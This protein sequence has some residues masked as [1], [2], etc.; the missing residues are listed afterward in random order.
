MKQLKHMRYDYIPE[1]INIQKPK[2]IIEIGV[3]K[4]ANAARMIAAL[5]GKV[6]YTGY[7]VF[8]FSDKEFHKLVGNGKEVYSKE[9]IYEDLKC[10][11]DDITLIKGMTQDTLW[12]NPTKAD[13]VFLDGDHRL[14]AIEGDY[15]A[16]Q[17]SEVVVFDDYY[18]NGS[19]NSFDNSKYGCYNFVNE[20]DNIIITPPTA[21]L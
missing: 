9:R 14:E 18:I 4:G 13:F 16:I 3:A 2:S 10:W 6:K 7:D 12:N 11:G 21:G 17:E 19:H 15:K 1:I 8:D 5:D 20:M